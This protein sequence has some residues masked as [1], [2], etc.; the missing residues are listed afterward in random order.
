[1]RLKRFDKFEKLNEVDSSS[2]ILLA[3]GLLQ[4]HNFKYVYGKDEKQL[5]NSPIIK[6][7]NALADIAKITKQNIKDIVS[8][9]VEEF[10]K[11]EDDKL[12]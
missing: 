6:T 12:K 1:M 8:P 10:L 4:L 3:A 9:E 7:L 5:Q 2:L 11:K